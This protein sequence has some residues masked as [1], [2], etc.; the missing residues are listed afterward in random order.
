M[1]YKSAREQWDAAVAAEKELWV[2]ANR[3]RVRTGSAATV[4]EALRAAERQV[5]LLVALVGRMMKEFW[6]RGLSEG[7]ARS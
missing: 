6:G 7:V 2:L 5:G 4:A 3:V 1:S